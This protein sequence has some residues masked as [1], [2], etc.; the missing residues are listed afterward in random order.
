MA[1]HIVTCAFLIASAHA[2]CD[3]CHKGEDGNAL[4]QTKTSLSVEESS[5]QE[6]HLQDKALLQ[7]EAGEVVEK[8]LQED[9]EKEE[10]GEK[11]EEG[12]EDEEEEDEEE[13]EDEEEEEENAEEE[14]EE[15]DEEK[16]EDEEEEEENAEEE[17][18]EEE[19]GGR[20][21]RCR[22]SKLGKYIANFA[23]R[24]R[25]RKVPS[26]RQGTTSCWD[27]AYAALEH[28]KSAGLKPR[29]PTASYVWSSK[30]VP[31]SQAQPGDIA[32]FKGWS[33]K[34]TF[35][36][37]WRTKSAGYPHT[38]VVTS[39]YKRGALTTYEQNP[40][41]VKKGVYHPSKRSWGSVTIYRMS[42]SSSSSSSGGGKLKSCGANSK[43]YCFGYKSGGGWCWLTHDGKSNFVKDGDG[44][45]RCSSYNGYPSSRYCQGAKR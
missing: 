32:Q 31:I 22:P 27:L 11:E 25:G 42:S 15:Q 14:E 9:E 24:N 28:A 6:N 20:S 41:P 37:G 7:T 38:A 26:R 4:L 43:K 17:E 39:C 10:V 45:H 12:D 19:E 5:Q 33:E 2:S 3:G 36:G 40:S 44:G 21:S 29:M 23:K 8:G 16:E 13:K 1:W 34:I 35:P 18:E 30:T